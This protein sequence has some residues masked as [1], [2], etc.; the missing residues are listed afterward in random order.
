MTQW[1]QIGIEQ[2]SK[3]LK[4]D[5]SGGL[6][7]QEATG[8]LAKYGPNQLQEKKAISPW[9]IFFGQF[10]DFIIW[11]LIGAAIVSGFLQEWIDALA[12]IAIVVLN[13]ILGFIQEYVMGSTSSYR[14]SSLCLATSSSLRRVTIYPPTA[15][16]SGSPL[17]SPCRKRA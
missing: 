4:T 8:R 5:L 3:N 13:A 6:T 2:I 11:V 10:K 17:I 16:W 15:G 1:W 9:S 14:L 7:S 12:I